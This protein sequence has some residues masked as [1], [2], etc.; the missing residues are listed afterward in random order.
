MLLL[1]KADVLKGSFFPNLCMSVSICRSFRS[2]AFTTKTTVG[3]S[4]DVIFFPE[5]PESPIVR[6]SIPGPRGIEAIRD[7]SRVFDTKSV[8]MVVDYKKSHGNYIVDVDG[9]ALLDV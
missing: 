2:R 7:L 6:T 9:N 4:K 8:G 1:R 5:E 3:T